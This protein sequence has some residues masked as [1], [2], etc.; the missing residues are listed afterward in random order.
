MW[1]DQSPAAASNNL[2]RTLHALRHTLNT[3]LGAGTAAAT[4]AFEDGV[5][6]LDE[7][8]WVDIAEFDRLGA[9]PTNDDR[10][11]DNLTQA[12]S[13]YQG[14][15]LPH[16]LYADWT[17]AP[18]EALRRQRREISLALVNHYRAVHAYTDVI[19]LLTPLL[20]NDP[21]DE[22]VH[23]ELNASLCTRRPPPRCAA[24][25]SGLR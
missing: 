2:Y 12:L 25:V 5:L 6:I 21:A 7:A 3:T 17:I 20:T 9:T 19:A 8:V 18:R 24:P 15:L 4:L 22:P 1:P 23:R 16:D 11:I 14:D 10:R 13:L